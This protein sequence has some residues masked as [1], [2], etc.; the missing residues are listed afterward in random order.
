MTRSLAATLYTVARHHARARSLLAAL[1]LA[2][3]S[4][5]AAADTGCAALLARLE[6]VRPEAGS[7]LRTT[8]AGG[9][10][11]K[12]LFD[13]CD[14]TDTFAGAPLPTHRAKPLRCSSD[15][16]KVAFIRRY[17]DGTIVFRA[18]MGVDADGA[19]ISSGGGRSTTDQP[20]TSLVYDRGSTRRFT[21][22]EQVPFIVVPG[23]NRALGVDFMGRTG[24]RV[25]DLAVAMSA[26]G[27]SFGVVGDVGP[28]FRLGEGSLRTHDELGHPRCV[29]RNQRPCRRIRDRSIPSDVTYVVFP[30]SRPTPLLWQTGV[31][32]AKQASAARLETFLAAQAGDGVARP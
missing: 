22:A 27:C 32:V 17:A 13:Q 1:G 11:Y 31:A 16:N 5:A 21:D 15:P 20:K 9:P 30:R 18:K 7:E 25:G 24:V 28:Y 6:A 8:A 14:R 19:P 3:Y 2:L 10:T 12:S 23:A 26:S 29:V 4:T